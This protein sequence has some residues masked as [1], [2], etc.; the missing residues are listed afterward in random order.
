MVLR[1][2]L[3]ARLPSPRTAA[4]QRGNCPS[5]TP[6]TPYC[7]VAK[8]ELPIPDFLHPILLRCKEGTAHPRLPPPRAKHS[9]GRQTGSSRHL[10]TNLFILSAQVGPSIKK[11]KGRELTNS[12][13]HPK[14]IFFCLHPAEVTQLMHLH[15]KSKFFTD[16]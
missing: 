5:Q 9:G 1:G 10:C 15:N 16:K 3:E 11:S 13:A 2:Y 14:Q 8:R 4:L 6:S 12:I 7:C